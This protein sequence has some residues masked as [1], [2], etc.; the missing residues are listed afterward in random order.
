MF[1]K[2]KIMSEK[3]HKLRVNS[4]LLGRGGSITSPKILAWVRPP[5]PLF[6][7]AEISKAPGHTTPLFEDNLYTMIKLEREGSFSQ[8]DN[9][10]KLCARIN[11]EKLIC[12][13][14]SDVNDRDATLKYR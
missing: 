14:F 5:I 10:K 7:N 1:W 3:I 11:L 4:R 2:I 8:N 12:N 13:C 9:D 6:G